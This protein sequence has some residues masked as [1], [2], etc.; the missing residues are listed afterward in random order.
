MSPAAQTAIEYAFMKTVLGALVLLSF[1]GQ[2]QKTWLTAFGDEL[3]VFVS[4]FMTE[5]RAIAVTKN[6]IHALAFQA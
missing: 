5:V 2:F 3:R 6:Q 1:S 4:H